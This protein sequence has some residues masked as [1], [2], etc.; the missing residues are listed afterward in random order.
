MLQ[1]CVQADPT[2]RHWFPNLSIP[3][4]DRLHMDWFN[5]LQRRTLTPENAWR[6]SQAVA[7]VDISAQLPRLRVPALVLHS[8]ADRVAPLSGGAELARSIPG[9]R[10]VELESSNHILLAEEPAFQQFVGEVTGFA[11]SVFQTRAIVPIDHRTRRQATILCADFVSPVQ[12]MDEFFPEMALEIVDPLLM[13]AAEHVRA[14]GGTVLGVTES[15]LTASFGAPD[16]LEG[17]AALACRTALEL[18]DMVRGDPRSMTRVRVAL[19]TGVVIVGPARVAGSA[20]VEVR[21]GPVTIVDALSQALRRDIVAATERTRN[22]A[23]GFVGMEALLP[24]AV[25]GFS[26]DQH[27]YEVLEIKRGRSRWQLRS[28]RQLSPFVGREMPLQIIN[29]AWH[30]ARG[31]EGQSVLVV[32][33]PGIGKSRVT[34]EFVGAIPQDEA[35]NLEAGALETDFR[36]GFVVVRKVL[37]SLFGVDEAEAPLSAVDKVLAAQRERGFDERLL[38]PILAVMELPAQDPLWGGISGQERSRRM[39]EAVVALLLFL[40]RSKAIVLLVE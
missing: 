17:H 22:S 32:G 25:T 6:I 31:G 3:G 7:D 10:F 12:A 19:D 18:R 28:H 11:N 9:A 30:D 1:C 14:N 23:G 40:A 37:Q 24:Q 20:T 26:K 39:Q 4:A 16:A 8:R 38:E 13:K 2:F 15:G 5:E 29:K 21:G 35:E 36:Y 27:L 33:D 34:H